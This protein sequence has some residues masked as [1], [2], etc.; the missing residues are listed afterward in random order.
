MKNK[1]S[2]QNLHCCDLISPET[3]P[4]HII[5]KDGQRDKIFFSSGSCDAP[6]IIFS[7]FV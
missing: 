2:E 7:D 6:K 3:S 5:K 1:N 4:Y